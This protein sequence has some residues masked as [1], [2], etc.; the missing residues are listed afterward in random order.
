MKAFFQHYNESS[1]RWE[2]TELPEQALVVGLPR[3]G[4]TVILPD[5]GSFVAKEVVYDYS[6]NRVLVELVR[7]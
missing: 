2:D 4:D 3:K 1:R 6:G 7:P 5:H